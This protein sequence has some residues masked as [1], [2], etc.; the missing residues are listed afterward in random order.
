M[1]VESQHEWNKQVMC[2][3]ESLVGLLADAM[4]GGGIHQHH[5]QKHYMSSDTTCLGKVNLNCSLRPNLILFN[6]VEAG[7]NQQRSIGGA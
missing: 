7:I 4:V 2:I 5:A 1:S 6:I 3:P